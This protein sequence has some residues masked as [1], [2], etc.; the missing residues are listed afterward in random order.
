MNKNILLVI[1][2]GILLIGTASASI[3]FLNVKNYNGETET[4]KIKGLFGIGGRLAEYNETYNTDYCF[5][6]CYAEGTAVLYSEGKLFE[7]LKFE[8]LKGKEK[9]IKEYKILIGKEKQVFEIVNATGKETKYVITW[10]EY[11][12]EILSEGV[13]DWRIE[14]KK[15]RNEDVEW[16]VTAYGKDL[17]EWD[18]WVGNMKWSLNGTA[19]NSMPDTGTYSKVETFWMDGALYSIIG[20][21]DG[22]FTG[23]VWD[24]TAHVWVANDTI[25]NGLGDIG[26]H[27]N[28]TVFVIEEERYLLSG[29]V[30]TGLVGFVWD[31]ANHIW[32]ANDTINSSTIEKVSTYGKPDVFQLNDGETYMLA[33]GL[34]AGLNGF[35]WDIATHTWLPNDTINS[36][37]PLIA[38][39]TPN[40]FN[41]TNTFYSMIGDEDGNFWGWVW[42]EATH[43]SII[44]KTINATITKIGSASDPSLFWLE[45]N[46]YMVSGSGDGGSSGQW[47]NWTYVLSSLKL[48]LN[49]PVNF[50]NS[51]TTSITF[52]VTTESSEIIEN[53]SLILDGLINYTLTNGVTN[54]S[55][56][57]ITLNV[58]EGSHNWTGISL[59]AI[60]Q[61]RTAINRSF[62]VDL[63]PP[64]INLSAMNRTID[65]WVSGNNISFNWTAEDV[66]TGL[67][68]C[69]ITFAESNITVPCGDNNISINITYDYTNLSFYAKDNAGNEISEV[70][71]WNYKIFQHEVIYNL[72][73]IE[74]SAENFTINVSRGDDFDFNNVL[75]NYNNTNYSVSY[76][77]FTNQLITKE[78]IV[79]D[80]AI[81]TNF[82]F[83]WMFNF[84]DFTISTTRNYNQTASGLG[85]D[86]CSAFTIPL[87]NITLKDEDT[88]VQVNNGT[89]YTSIKLSFAIY[90]LNNSLVS[91]YSGNFSKINPVKICIES[92][93][94][95]ESKYRLDGLIEYSSTNRFTEFYN[96][97]NYQLSNLTTNVTLFLYDLNSSKGT[98]FKITYK[99]TN[100]IAIQDTIL[101]IQRKYIEDGAFKTI[102]IPKTGS[103]G[104]TVGHFIINDVIY[105]I[106]VLREGK[107][108]A[109]FTD[110][111]AECQNPALQACEINLNEVSSSTLPESFET[112][113]DLIFNLNYNSTSREV[114]SIVS[115]LS[116]TVSTIELNVTLFDNLGNRSVCYDN[117]IAA[118]GELICAVPGSFG[119]STIIASLYKD[120]AKVGQ[121]IITIKENPSDIYGSNLIFIAIFGVLV[122]FGI[123]IVD[124]PMISG[125]ILIIGV[126]FMIA[127]NILASPSIVGVGA[128]VL[129]FIVAIVLLLIKGSKRQ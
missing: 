95:N 72:E 91:N 30:V 8:D 29:E 47:Y 78:I 50:Y 106:I 88:Q 31:S 84:T 74:G 67:K 82:T 121:S 100:F 33:G 79:P 122:I 26:G 68:E 39:A 73:T 22:T 15:E 2:L 49:N 75:F 64:V 28:P 46:L 10:K 34:T 66:L 119:N 37:Y 70:A 99:D 110:V 123:M 125:I 109:T 89:E 23:L 98:P 4:I 7:D 80:V 59:D 11:N 55:E 18:E 57:Y 32:L 90:T 105:N 124:N 62:V 117:L 51:S 1:L 45:N 128:T 92:P 38:Y 19:N 36:S 129:W 56:L 44:N 16:I 115:V 3:N 48:A 87:F 116:G 53:V 63:T 21:A 24:N 108:L 52:N 65:Y 97:Q 94:I 13:Y 12:G 43:T 9:A 93:L 35:V 126:I 111:V 61:N 71:K 6:D 40:I 60:G 127:L 69:I 85:I 104:Y 102:E 120:G 81:E 118:G 17:I 96:F 14:G 112:S 113:D 27:A 114:S 5:E 41:I 103:A 76:T 25:V 20:D 83:Y 42:D 58:P 77:N 101:Q 107:I 54:F 86:D